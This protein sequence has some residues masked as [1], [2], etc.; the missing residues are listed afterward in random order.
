MSPMVPLK[1]ALRDHFQRCELDPARLAALQRLT[2]G[3]AAPGAHDRRWLQWAATA[4]AAIVA[5]ALVLF[6]AQGSFRT[7][8]LPRRAAEE[9]TLNHLAQKPLD[10]LNGNLTALRPAFGQLDFALID[11][12]V[13]ASSDWTLQGG[14]YCSV[15]SVPAAQLRYHDAAGDAITAYQAPYQPERHGRLP[16]HERGEEPLEFHIRGVRVR[17]WTEH[18][19]LLATAQTVPGESPQ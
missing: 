2:Q 3:E 11:S 1:Q 13:L 4:A 16:A 5:V 12:P 19:L 17:L 7:A 18:G 9:I 14:R 6:L 8:D 10:V 15:Q